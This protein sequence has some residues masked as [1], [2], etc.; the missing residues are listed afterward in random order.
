MLGV[1]VGGSPHCSRNIGDGPINVAP[2]GGG[3]K[4][5]SGDATGTHLQKKLMVEAPISTPDPGSWENIDKKN[6][7]KSSKEYYYYYYYFNLVRI[8]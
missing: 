3:G 7:S 4:K 6:T 8:F 1:Y 2:S 5:S